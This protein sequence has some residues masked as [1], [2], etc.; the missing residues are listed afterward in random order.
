MTSRW[1]D[2]QD[3]PRTVRELTEL[4][5]AEFEGFA[6]EVV[7]RMYAPHGII[8]RASG[9][10]PDGG[11]DAEGILDLGSVAERALR[12][13]LWVE[14]KQHRRSVGRQQVGG[15][16]FA[17]I[18]ASANIVVIVSCS[19]FSKNFFTDIA[20]FSHRTGIR[21]QLMSGEELLAQAAAISSQGRTALPAKASQQTRQLDPELRINALYFSGTPSMRGGPGPSW[22]PVPAGSPLFAIAK[23]E[24]RSRG[25][26]HDIEIELV[27]TNPAIVP[28]PLT[29]T[30][31][32][33]AGPV[34]RIASIFLLQDLKAEWLSA[35]QFEVHVRLGEQSNPQAAKVIARPPLGLSGRVPAVQMIAPFIP[36]TA[37]RA[38]ANAAREIHRECERWRRDGGMV[39]VSVEAAAGVGKSAL[40]NAC[41]LSWLQD[42]VREVVLDGETEATVWDVFFAVLAHVI[43]VDADMAKS[44]N[45]RAFAKWFEGADTSPEFALRL[46]RGICTKEKEAGGFSPGELQDL[47]TVLLRRLAA[48]GPVAFV[49]EDLHKVGGSVLRLLHSTCRTLRGDAGLRI[50]FFFTS[51]FLPQDHE[52]EG[53]REAWSFERERLLGREQTRR[54]QLEMPDQREAGAI[55]HAAVKHLYPEMAEDIITRSG[56]TPFGI[57]EVLRYLVE[58]RIL[59]LGDGTEKMVVNPAADLKKALRDRSLLASTV[60]EKRL[61]LLSSR[62][63]EWASEVLELAACVG[64][65]FDLKRLLRHV[66]TAPTEARHV[67]VVIGELVQ[68]GV[69]SISTRTLG[70]GW[71]FEHDLI[72]E[73]ILGRLAASHSRLRHLRLVQA[74]LQDQGAW[75]DPVRLSLIYQSGRGDEFVTESRA[76][77][78]SL[79]ASG[80]PYEA[81]AFLTLEDAVLDPVQEIA[82]ADDPAFRVIPRPMTNGPAAIAELID[83]K[84]RLFQM[85]SQVS[86]G[87]GDS[88][89][90]LI[91]EV[92]MLAAK[93]RNRTAAALAER[94]DGDFNISIGDPTEAIYRFRAAQA[95]YAGHNEMSTSDRF[96][97]ALGEAIALRLVGK[98]EE[99][100]VKLSQALSLDAANP[101]SQIRYHANYGALFFYTD[102]T[103]RREHWFKAL[104]IAK[105]AKLEDLAVHMEL[106]LASL[107]ILDRHLG[108]ARGRLDR[109]AAVAA[110]RR[111]ENSLMRALIMTSGLDLVEGGPEA[112]LA[113]LDEARRLG[114]AHDARRR[115]WKV[116]A[117]SANAYE[118]LGMK[119]RAIHEDRCM[120]AVLKAVAWE[121]R[122]ALAPTN[123]VMRIKSSYADKFHETLAASISEEVKAVIDKVLESVAS[124]MPLSGRFPQEHLFEIAGRWRFIAV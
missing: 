91:S 70:H 88:A 3:R 119:D 4:S 55:I 116:H 2:R 93:S 23:Y 72:R 68:N 80:H 13:T 66:A 21:Y 63:P 117:N 101:R 122:I 123:L 47:F 17:A 51:R 85:L 99:S 10:G 104:D 113:N 74:L 87:A 79:A 48:A 114:Y 29:P 42:S 28:L 102:P 107:D 7:G 46:A 120:V 32:R 38:Q 53:E 6:L 43:P 110:E 112:A 75:A 26:C 95:I 20:H 73:A 58:A 18:S 22:L 111:F 59:S 92:R 1:L 82:S 14:V 30:K 15:H 108:D 97:A 62:V 31:V 37:T 49:F 57:S 115:L 12:L 84:R 76:Y 19:G 8:L 67:D 34:E 83:V 9:A 11:R 52:D 98:T 40:L 109:L 65:E 39:S 89:E 50:L 45:I 16:I 69:L 121:R 44:R 54:F 100:E 103:M 105:Q 118:M 106:D 64:R 90:R 124:G 27:C 35:D 56:H 94:W 36:Y 86:G 24:F 61:A 81:A 33:L 5:W 77:S 71:K 78:E 96:E 25:G 41:R 60:T